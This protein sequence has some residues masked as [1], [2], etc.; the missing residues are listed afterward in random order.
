MNEEILAWNYGKELAE[1][2]NF[3]YGKEN[4]DDYMSDCIMSHVR[5]GLDSVYGSEINA[6][7]IY[8]KRV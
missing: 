7:I 6:R 2:L 3:I 5:N 1:R 8:T 4:L